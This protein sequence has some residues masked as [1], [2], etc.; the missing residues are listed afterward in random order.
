M[1]CSYL[2]R[3]D[4][5]SSEAGVLCRS[6]INNRNIDAH[7]ERSLS[8]NPPGSI[9]IRVK[10][11]SRYFLPALA[12]SHSLAW[13]Q[14]RFGRIPRSNFGIAGDN[15]TYDYVVVGGGTAGLALA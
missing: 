12:A 8:S 10:T 14:P 7:C 6:H 15:A 2:P 4:I 9:F 13:A 5:A 1:M 3:L 11:M